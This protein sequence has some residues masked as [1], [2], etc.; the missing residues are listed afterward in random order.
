MG[1]HVSPHN[2]HDP[3]EALLELFDKYLGYWVG[4]SPRAA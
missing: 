3:V 2:T 4:A 1:G